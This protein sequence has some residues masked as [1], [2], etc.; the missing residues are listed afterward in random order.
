MKGALETQNWH[1][2]EERPG[3]ELVGWRYRGPFDELGGAVGRRP[4][5]G[6]L[7]RG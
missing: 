7:D 3:A 2:V 4:S 5:R 1:V 6:G